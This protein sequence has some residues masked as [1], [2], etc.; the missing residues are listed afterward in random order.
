MKF[1]VFKWLV[2][3]LLLPAAVYAQNPYFS[4]YYASPLYLNPALS[5]AN[6][7]ISF[8]VNHR[9]QWNSN[10]APYEISQFSLMYPLLTRGARQDHLGGVGLSVFKDVSGEGGVLKSLGISAGGSYRISLDQNHTVLLGL[11]GGLIQKSVD[12]GNL[13]WGSQYDNIIG[14]D[15]RIAPSVGEFKEST[16]LPV[17]DAGA[18]WHYASHSR[19]S[20][21]PSRGWAFF[22]GLSVSN[23]NRP[24]ESFLKDGESK[25]PMLFKL[26][27]GVDYRT[28]RNF[29]FSPSYLL[30]YQNGNT[31]YNIGTYITWSLIADAYS[32][33]PKVFDLQLGAWHRI[34]D[35]FIFLAGLSGRSFA[36][37]F[38]YDIN[39]T[40]MRYNNLGKS[41]YEISLKYKIKKG[42]EIRR[43]STPLM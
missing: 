18:F 7:E 16:L 11:Q 12:F 34:H 19:S 41:A 25:L 23:I 13:R 22:N 30:M 15:D 2:I 26:H 40:S 4:Q 36:L 27:G 21:M 32:R 14:Y 10:N 6:R 37:G 8:G 33:N 38:S 17:F 3:L 35:S 28:S 5:G 29:K 20:F 1:E 42:N 9:S 31:Q 43:F 24:D 39:S